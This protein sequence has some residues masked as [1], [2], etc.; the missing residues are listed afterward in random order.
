MVVGVS[1]EGLRTASALPK[2]CVHV[3]WRESRFW[4]AH[5]RRASGL[6]RLDA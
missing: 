6:V 1:Q 2:V 4:V 3:I 5:V